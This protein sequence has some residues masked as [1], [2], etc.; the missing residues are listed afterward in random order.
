MNVL[1]TKIQKKYLNMKNTRIGKLTLILLFTLAI[2]SCSDDFLDQTN[3]NEL[4]TDSFWKTVG[5]LNTG[6]VATYKSYGSDNNYKLLDELVRSDLAWGSGYQRPF[7]TNEFYLQNFNEASKS[8]GDKWSQLY[9]T[10]F[11]ANQVIE[12]VDRLKG[13]FNSQNDEDE[14]EVIG[15]Q[16]RFLRGFSY[17]ILSTT[18]NNGKVVIWEKVPGGEDGFYRDV[19]PAQDVKDFYRADL[20]YAKT[21]LPAVWEAREKGRVTAG[22]AE[23]VL[24]QSYLADNDFTTAAEYFK[25]VINNYGYALTPNIG[26]N[27]TTMDELNEESILEIVRST[28]YKSELNQWDWRDTGASSLQQQLTGIGGWFGGV[29]ANWLI[30]EYR[31]DPLDYSD[32]RNKIIEEDGTERFRKFSLRTSYS[33]AIVDDPDLEY[34]GYKTTAEAASFNVRMTCYWR[35]Q[36]NWDLGVESEKALSPG[37]VRSGVNQRLIRLAEIYLQYA[38]CLIE[39]G[40]VDEAMMYINKVRR[41]SGVQLLGLSGTGEYPANDHDDISYDA[42]SLM[43]HL[44]FKE[45]PLELSC[46]GHGATRNTDLRR[47]G[48]KKQRFMELAAKR[49]TAIDYPYTKED[50]T[51]AT[52][53]GSIVVGVDPSD[54]TADDGWNEYQE[55]AA[56]Y[57]ESEHAYWKIPNSEAITN[58][59]IGEN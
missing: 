14:A 49:Y 54:P 25:N 33:V 21:K 43:D 4:S 37:K 17:F 57:V 40:D 26:S 5:D 52:R 42:T 6:L 32:P 35:K 1:D 10:I 22:A 7:N 20:E 48:I 16:A 15:A 31:N 18:F 56:N 46:E 11:R 53:W 30:L 51:T 45:Y 23:A 9:T 8:P 28:D 58:P 19:S 29:A 59:V 36:T 2:V 12:A 55:A 44:R 39:M 50:G 24:G 27:F 47:W 3:P 13:T 41:R 34:Y 38:E